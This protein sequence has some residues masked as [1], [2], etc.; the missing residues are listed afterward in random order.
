MSHC[1]FWPVTRQLMLSD[2]LKTVD[3]AEEGPL[4]LWAHDLS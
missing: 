1:L 3:L 4:I 2:N